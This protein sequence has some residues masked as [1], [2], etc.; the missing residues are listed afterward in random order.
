MANFSVRTGLV[1]AP[2]AEGQVAVQYVRPESDAARSGIKPGDVLTSVNSTETN[3]IRAL[4]KYLTGHASQSAFSVGM[5]RGRQNFTQPL[6]RQVSL[7]GVRPSIA[8]GQ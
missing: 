6:G 3:T 2:N 7:L 8:F 4:Q 5:G 1:L